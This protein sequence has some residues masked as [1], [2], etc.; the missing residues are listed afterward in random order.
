MEGVDFGVVAFDV[1]PEV[2]GQVPGQ[3]VQGRVVQAGAAFLQVVDDQGPD[4]A[5]GERVAVDELGTAE[6]ASDPLQEPQGGRG[7]GWQ[8]AQLAQPRVVEGAAAADAAGSAS[9]F[10]VVL[11]HVAHGDVR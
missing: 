8:V 6:L 10:G 7:V 4:R 2:P 1:G 5:G 11:Q 3:V 9:Q